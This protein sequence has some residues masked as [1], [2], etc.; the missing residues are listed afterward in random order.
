LGR[1]QAEPWRVHGKC[2][3]NARKMLGKCIKKK[4]IL[5]DFYVIQMILLN[6]KLREMDHGGFHH[7]NWWFHHEKWGD[8]GIYGTNK[9]PKPEV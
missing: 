9:S 8:H 5:C 7:P 4:A 6:G 3:E 2:Q 1:F